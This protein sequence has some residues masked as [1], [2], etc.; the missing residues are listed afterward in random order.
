[1]Q[2]DIEA[3]CLFFLCARQ[4]RCKVY[5]GDTTRR[6]EGSL[7]DLPVIFCNGIH[8]AATVA[9][10]QCNAHALNR[11]VAVYVYERD[12]SVFRRTLLPLEQVHGPVRDASIH[13]ARVV[14]ADGVVLAFLP[15]AAGKSTKVRAVFWGDMSLGAALCA[16]CAMLGCDGRVRRLSWRLLPVV[17]SRCYAEILR[18]IERGA[19]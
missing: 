6:A 11:R 18:A 12:V 2:H 15:P 14:D 7:G 8:A 17:S 3:V 10:M 4:K 1:M 19:R 9:P 16:V 13:H 5:H